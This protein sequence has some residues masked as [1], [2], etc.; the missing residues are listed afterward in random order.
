VA[1]PTLEVECR[2]EEKRLRGLAYK[3][4]FHY[5]TR[6]PPRGAGRSTSGRCIAHSK[7]RNNFSYLRLACRRRG[8]RKARDS[9]SVIHAD[10]QR[11]LRSRSINVD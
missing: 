1:Y 3:I 2:V 10:A 9:S 11:S 6:S 8:H 5:V 4:L 7:N